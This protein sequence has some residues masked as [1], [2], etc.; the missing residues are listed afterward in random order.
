MGESCFYRKEQA[1]VEDWIPP[2]EMTQKRGVNIV[3]FI[4]N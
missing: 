4:M 3:V 2:P 1:Q